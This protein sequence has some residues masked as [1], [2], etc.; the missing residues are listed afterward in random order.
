MALKA[1]RCRL[2]RSHWGHFGGFSL[3]FAETSASVV[4]HVTVHAGKNFEEF[5]EFE[6]FFGICHPFN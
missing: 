1:V 2:A 5:E 6:E 4:L 3:K